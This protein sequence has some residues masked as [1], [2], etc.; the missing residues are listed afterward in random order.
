ML[1]RRESFGRLLKFRFF[2]ADKAEEQELGAAFAGG[3]KVVNYGFELAS[4]RVEDAD[5]DYDI[6]IFVGVKSADLRFALD[7]LGK[8]WI[9]C[10]FPYER[11]LIGSWY[12]VSVG[13]HQPTDLLSSANYPD[14]RL[15]AMPWRLVENAPRGDA[16]L[17]VGASTKYH[18]F[19]GLPAP[20]DWALDLIARL[21]TLTRSPII[22]RQKAQNTDLDALPG[23]EFSRGKTSIFDDLKRSRVVIITGSN[24]AFDAMT[25]N[26][27]AIILGD[28]ISRDISSTRL[29][30]VE[31]P[32]RATIEEKRKIFRNLAY[33]QWSLAQIRCGLA[34]HHIVE[35]I[36]VAKQMAVLF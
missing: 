22:Y 36:R 7:Y 30:E 2:A 28:A 4:N 5:G 29:E 32:R 20:D 3:F 17:I 25:V 14:D 23:A 35:Q 33:C 27:P 31:R 8:P 26:V 21:Q 9:Y 1:V 15:K 24:V 11:S 18:R 10:D 12:K 13:G 19:A 6:G 34:I 16:V